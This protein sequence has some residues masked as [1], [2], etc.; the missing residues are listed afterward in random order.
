MIV[1]TDDARVGHIDAKAN[2]IPTLPLL[3][4]E[5]RRKCG[6]EFP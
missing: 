6:L 4:K 2:S 1:V 5:D 3:G